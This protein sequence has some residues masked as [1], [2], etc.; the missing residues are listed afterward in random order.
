M[1]ASHLGSVALLRSFTSV[2]PPSSTPQRL[3][4]SLP[5][6]FGGVFFGVF[7]CCRCGRVVLR[8]VIHPVTHLVIRQSINS[9]INPSIHHPPSVNPPTRQSINPLINP[10]FYTSLLLCIH[11]NNNY[12]PLRSVVTWSVHPAVH[13]RKYSSDLI[14]S[15]GRLS[16]IHPPNPPLYFCISSSTFPT[17]Y[18][19]SSSSIVRHP[20]IY[21]VASLSLSI[22]LS[23]PLRLT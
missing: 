13:L 10:S 3:C 20:R 2:I 18:Q 17:I 15:C 4:R 11:L 23:R 8:L 19:Q 12:L 9:P 16:I 14:H 21:Q 1:S 7:V 22:P 5:S 6:A